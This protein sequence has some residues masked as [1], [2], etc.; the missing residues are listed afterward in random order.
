MFSGIRSA[1]GIFDRLSEQYEYWKEYKGK[2][3]WI[4]R[5]DISRAPPDPDR[6]GPGPHQQ[7]VYVIRGTVE[8]VMS[9]PPGFLLKDVQELVVQSDFTLSF[10]VNETEAQNIIPGPE[11]QEIIR[12]IDRKFVSF[13]SI[14]QLERG[15]WVENSREPYRDVWPPEDGEE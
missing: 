8:D 11:A 6:I 14:D 2:E 13:D 9:F 10:T 7:T 5:H 1:L 4:R 15:D 12:E 3:I